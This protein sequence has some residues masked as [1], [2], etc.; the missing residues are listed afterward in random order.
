MLVVCNSV[1]TGISVVTERL[2]SRLGSEARLP[3]LEP[4]LPHS[5]AVCCNFSSMSGGD[6][7]VDSMCRTGLRYKQV[8]IVRALIFFLYPLLRLFVTLVLIPSREN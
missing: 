7:K 1:F 8:D 5:L 2:G 4:W 3:G 6:S